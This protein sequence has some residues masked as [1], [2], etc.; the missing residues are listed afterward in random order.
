MKINGI[1]NH[2]DAYDKLQDVIDLL[3]NSNSIEFKINLTIDEIDSEYKEFEDDYEM[4]LKEA[5]TE[6]ELSHPAVLRMAIKKGIFKEKEIRLVG[7][8]Y[9]IKQS[10]VERYRHEYKGKRGFASKKMKL[11]RRFIKYCEDEE[12]MSIKDKETG[13]FWELNYVE[14]E[15][16]PWILESPDNSGSSSF[17]DKPTVE[18][19]IESIK[20]HVTCIF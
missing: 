3:S 12:S 16:Y 14:N 11:D 15:E 18:I 4:T 7:T 17:K 20:K 19:V 6:L 13:L 10:A 1:Y 9:L 8:T 2:T 5:A